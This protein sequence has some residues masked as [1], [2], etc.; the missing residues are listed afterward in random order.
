MDSAL[1]GIIC[2]NTFCT[3]QSCSGTHYNYYKRARDGCIPVA[4]TGMI[5][6]ISPEGYQV[7]QTNKINYLVTNQL[8]TP[9]QTD[10]RVKLQ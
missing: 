5:V 1:L 7:Y 3:G 4:M 2:S 6:Y 8:S 9:E 10:K